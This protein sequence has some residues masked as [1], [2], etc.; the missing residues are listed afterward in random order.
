VDQTGWRPNRHHGLPLM[1]LRLWEALPRSNH[2][3]ERCRLSYRIHFSSHVT[4]RWRKWIVVAQKKR[5]AHFITMKFLTF[6]L[7]MRHPFV[8]LLWFSKLPEVI[9]NCWMIYV[10]TASSWIVIR[11]S[12]STNIFNLSL[13]TADRRLD[14]VHDFFIFKVV[15]SIP[16]F[17]KLTLYRTFVCDSLTKCAVTSRLCCFMI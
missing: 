14:E 13:S 1:Q 10:F 8:E 15:I 4:M 5:R 16:K 12:V 9:Q 11:G 7:F 3:A 17:L 6:I 2:C